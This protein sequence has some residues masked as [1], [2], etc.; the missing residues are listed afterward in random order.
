MAPELETISR[1]FNDKKL[2]AKYKK[3]DEVVD[4]LGKVVE[5]DSYELAG[6]EYD[7]DNEI[8]VFD[9]PVKLD[10]RFSATLETL[11]DGDKVTVEDLENPVPTPAGF[12]F[13]DFRL[14]A[15]VGAAAD[16]VL[17]FDAINVVLSA[18]AGADFTYRHLLPIK[19][20]R[21]R[22]AAFK[23]TLS[24][25]RLPGDLD[26]APAKFHPGEI[27]QYSKK[28]HLTFGLKLNAGWTF[29]ISEV[30]D[31]FAELTIKAEIEATLEASMGLGFYDDMDLLVA[32]VADD[33][34]IRLR[35][36]RKRK[37]ALSLG[38]RLAIQADFDLGGTSLIS[39][40]DE[41]LGTDPAKEILVALAEVRQVTKNAVG[42]TWD[43][44]KKKISVR[45]GEA[46]DDF[47]DNGKGWK[48]WLKDSPEV[49]QILMISEKV[50]DA[51]LDA[52]ETIRS[53][54]S[55]LL[56]ELPLGK[57]SKLIKAIESVKAL[58]PNDPDLTRLSDNDTVRLVESLTGKD[59]EDLIF[60]SAPELSADLARAKSLATEA[61]DFLD[62][63]PVGLSD[64]FRAFSEK[65]GLKKA[66]DFL[67]KFNSKSK[68]EEAATQRILDLAARLVGKTWGEISDTDFK[69]IQKAAKRLDGYLEKIE[70]GPDEIRAA[71]G[72]L[73]GEFG[74]SLAL[75][76][77]RVTE[78]TALLDMEFDPSKGALTNSVQTGLQNRD[79]AKLLTS[80]I[81]LEDKKS[82]DESDALPFR[83]R[84][85]VFTR[86]RTSTGTLSLI[87]SLFGNRSAVS[88]RIEEDIVRTENG[89]RHGTYS[90]GFERTFSHDSCSSQAAVW[91]EASTMSTDPRPLAAFDELSDL[92]LRWAIAKTNAATKQNEL[93]DL[94]DFL[95]IL[96][97]DGPKISDIVP[98]RDGIQ[99]RFSLSM[100]LARSA[101]DR[102]LAQTDKATW[103]GDYAQA[104]ETWAR[105]FL[106][107]NQTV[108]Q[109]STVKIKD[110]LAKFLMMP[111]FQ[112]MAPTDIAPEAPGAE[113]RFNLFSRRRFEI[114]PG[115]AP[116]PPERVAAQLRSYLVHRA[117]GFRKQ[118]KLADASEKMQ[119]LAPADLRAWT[120]AAAK[121]FR[122]AS[123]GTVDLGNPM[124]VIWLCLE[125]IV[126]KTGHHGTGTASLRWR[127]NN[128]QDWSAP[129]FWTLNSNS[130][131]K[132]I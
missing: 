117:A 26:L 58:D 10:A 104:A 90:G 74:F 91:V 99:T 72:K 130:L 89:T 60:S 41:V 124:F 7:K 53:W 29:N 113:S 42:G 103:W 37:R 48:K 30:V 97:F 119:A 18:G 118:G 75:N 69:S 14:E 92:G 15:S 96:Q 19:H 77:E 16:Q 98:G 13:T 62:G 35:I 59:L 131:F 28:F 81:D 100:K 45:A 79:I 20:G 56:G 127:D 105:S 1:I 78:T 27:Q 44:I 112:A 107:F 116:V 132:D 63:I 80:M 40:L 8:K 122:S 32:R 21:K 95:G 109:K 102:V 108:D 66:V 51:Y 83:I 31:L 106:T 24:S 71:L 73:K 52:D 49:D 11:A 12:V 86:K 50:V 68:L 23:D 47:I 128:T 55:D 115:Q 125:R 76:F 3:V 65:I 101:A 38:A 2:M 34:W 70:D 84:E 87:S 22:L 61:R 54:W 4:A 111:K 82:G 39:I 126:D 123:T 94:Q 120:A 88:R 64:K 129:V 17:T 25:S 43:D 121:A 93:A 5:T 114:E 85:S 57:D 36:A 110:A 46:L 6:L 9:Q 67:S 33:D